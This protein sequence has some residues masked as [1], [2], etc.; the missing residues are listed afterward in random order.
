M[1]WTSTEMKTNVNLALI[2]FIV[3]TK[4]LCTINL[5]RETVHVH[6]TWGQTSMDIWS[7][8]LQLRNYEKRGHYLRLQT[9][10]FY[11][12][13]LYLFLSPPPTS[14]RFSAD[15][16]NSNRIKLWFCLYFTLLW[17]GTLISLYEFQICHQ[18]YR[19][20]T[21]STNRFNSDF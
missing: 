4:V 8:G 2:L 14:C 11:F 17:W 6:E 1:K 7:M 20:I 5:S 13:L 9:G 16:F 19:I 18:L 3:L 12:Y 15:W 21:A 10:H